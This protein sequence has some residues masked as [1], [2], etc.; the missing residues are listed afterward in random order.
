VRPP[1][2]DLYP[3]RIVVVLKETM[4]LEEEKEESLD[5]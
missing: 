5:V 3:S 4:H 2:G 1:S